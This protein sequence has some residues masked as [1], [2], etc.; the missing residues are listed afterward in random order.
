[1]SFEVLEKKIT[2]LPE[3]YINEVIDFVD[4]LVAKS[5]STQKIE[6]NY[7]NRKA[8]IAKDP[9]FFMAPDFDEPLECFKDYM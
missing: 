7:P 4:F 1:M 6:H 3:N 9:N 2:L 5:N 8:G